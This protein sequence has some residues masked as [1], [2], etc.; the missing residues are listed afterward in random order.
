MRSQDLISPFL[1][2][3]RPVVAASTQWLPVEPIPEQGLIAPVRNDVINHGRRVPAPGA[4]WVTTQKHQPLLLPVG[5]VAT[6]AGARAV[7]VMAAIAGTGACDLARTARAIGH[8]LS[9]RTNMGRSRHCNVLSRREGPLGQIQ[10]PALRQC[11]PLAV[12]S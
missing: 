1:A 12:P 10:G 8:G 3:L 9:T 11:L 7:S 2:L 6:L 4:V 5:R